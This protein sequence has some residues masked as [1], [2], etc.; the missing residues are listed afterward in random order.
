VADLNAPWYGFTVTRETAADRFREDSKKATLFELRDADR[1]L[2]LARLKE[3]TEG[4]ATLVVLPAGKTAVNSEHFSTRTVAVAALASLAATKSLQITLIRTEKRIATRLLRDFQPLAVCTADSAEIDDQP[5]SV[6]RVAGSLWLLPETPMHWADAEALGDNLIA[7]GDLVVRNSRVGPRPVGWFEDKNKAREVGR[8]TKPVFEVFRF[9]ADEH[10]TT[11][12]LVRQDKSLILSG[13][14]QASRDMRTDDVMEAIRR[15]PSLHNLWAHEATLIDCQGGPSDDEIA[16]ALKLRQH[17]EQEG[18]DAVW[19][20]SFVELAR[21]EEAPTMN[22][23][24]AQV[25]VINDRRWLVV[26]PGKGFRARL[27]PADPSEEWRLR[28]PFIEVW[29]TYSDIEWN[30]RV[31]GVSRWS[32]GLIAEDLVAD[33]YEVDEDEPY[34]AV[35]RRLSS[36]EL[37]VARWLLH[38]ESGLD[39][40]M[41]AVESLIGAAVGQG[42]VPASLFDDNG[43]DTMTCD[44]WLNLETEPF[45]QA[46]SRIGR[47]DAVDAVR[48]PR[49]KSAARRRARLPADEADE[50]DEE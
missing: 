48:K 7:V 38:H 26:P 44:L 3:N 23:I 30:S 35:S 14:G 6:V 29:A 17:H 19:F 21:L 22:D 50:A 39:L 27:L 10:F 32:L 41:L 13:D 12:R 28:P 43:S 33:L 8:Q 16:S 49:S 47:K 25:V 18:E 36:R 24:S 11:Y 5:I 45:L 34:I 1:Q 42:E 31:S 20:P 9:D 2:T 40:P 46:L 15:S 37:L 4:G